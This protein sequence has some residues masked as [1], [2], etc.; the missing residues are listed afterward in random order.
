MTRR[1]SAGPES[2]ASTTG[3]RRAPPLRF[4]VPVDPNGVPI[5]ALGREEAARSLGI[6]LRT[7]DELL[8]SDAIRT[9]RIG[10]RRVIPVEEIVR[11]LRDRS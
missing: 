7:L 5:L 3:N 6:G 8:A 11:Y 4:S 9:K 10:A 2:T 1:A